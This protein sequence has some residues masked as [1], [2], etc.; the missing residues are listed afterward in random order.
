MLPTRH[1]DVCAG[2]M[3]C[4]R[5]EFQLRISLQRRAVQLLKLKKSCFFC[6][7]VIVWWITFAVAQIAV[8]RLRL[9]ETL[10]RFLETSR[11]EREAA[12]AAIR[13]E[14]ARLALIIAQHRVADGRRVEARRVDCKNETSY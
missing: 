5:K 4:A 7:C 1:H 12:V 11:L 10:E 6:S 9:A 8:P 14:H 3:W 13:H 2:L